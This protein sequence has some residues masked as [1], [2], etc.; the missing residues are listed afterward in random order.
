MEIYVSLTLFSIFC[1]D[2]QLRKSASSLCIK[3]F[4]KGSRVKK[5]VH[6]EGIIISMHEAKSKTTFYITSD[7]NSLIGKNLPNN[8]VTTISFAETSIL[9]VR[10]FTVVIF[11][12]TWKRLLEEAWTNWLSRKLQLHQIFLPEKKKKKKKNRTLAF[13]SKTERVK[14]TD[15]RKGAHCSWRVPGRQCRRRGWSMVRHG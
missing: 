14:K 7:W 9:F 1:A 2:C 6:C 15:W 4:N 12:F 13:R 10:L 11:S 5:E 3:L 8:E